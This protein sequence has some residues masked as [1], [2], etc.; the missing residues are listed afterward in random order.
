MKNRPKGRS[1]PS[2]LWIFSMRFWNKPPIGL[3][4]GS[5]VVV[6][7]QR[8]DVCS[9]VGRKVEYKKSRG[10]DKEIILPRLYSRLVNAHVERA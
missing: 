8:S 6:L 10:D 7:L 5:Y 9:T 2:R 1:C 4:Y 3:F